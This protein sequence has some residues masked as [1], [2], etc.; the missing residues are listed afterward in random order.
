[1]FSLKFGKRDSY[2]RKEERRREMGEGGG[3]RIG[4]DRRG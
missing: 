1:M 2:G 4:V 3:E